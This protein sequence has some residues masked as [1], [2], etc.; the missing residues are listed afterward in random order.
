MSSIDGYGFNS[1]ECSSAEYERYWRVISF[2][3]LKLQITLKYS[4]LRH[5]FSSSAFA[6]LSFM[7]A[8]E[9]LQSEKCFGRL[10]HNFY[11][12]TI[13][14]LQWPSD[15]EL[16]FL[17]QHNFGF[18]DTFATPRH[19]QKMLFETVFLLPSA[20][21]GGSWQESNVALLLWW[22][23][24]CILSLRAEIKTN[25]QFLQCFWNHV[26]HASEGSMIWK[27]FFLVLANIHFP[28]M[29]FHV[30]VLPDQVLNSYI[31]G[32]DTFD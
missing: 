30:E 24:S 27:L 3:L 26:F 2:K 12:W 15:A 9:H 25:R 32:L 1:L 17:G 11:F 19:V 23:P 5:S 7:Y 6:N 29:C 4:T 28:R 14:S 18:F 22:W 13:S 20:L 8:Q 10:L 21:S 31:R 16:C